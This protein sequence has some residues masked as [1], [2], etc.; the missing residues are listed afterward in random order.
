MNRIISSLGISFWA[1]VSLAQ[2]TPDHLYN[3]VNKPLPVVV[4]AS[5]KLEIHLLEPVTAKDI[6]VAPVKAG[7][8]DLAQTLGLWSRQVKT[9]TY[10]QLY[11]DGRPQGA[12]IVLQPMLSPTVSKLGADGKTVVFE[13][14]EDQAYSGIRAY[15]DSYLQVE[16]S[17]G[18]M[19]FALR[20]DCA[21]NT[22]ANV[23]DYARNELYTDTIFHRVVYKRKDGTRFVIQGG[24]PAGTG[25]GGPG[26]AYALENSPLPHDFGVISIARST[27]PNTNGCQIFVCLSRDGTKHLDG[28]YASFGQL[29]RGAETVVKIALVKVGKDDR[30]EI[31]PVIKRVRLIPAD[32]YP[33]RPLPVSAPKWPDELQ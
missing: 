24:D 8:L 27:D 13:P 16:T 21:P 4:K 19:T 26:W 3:A 14:D 11:A 30:P 7:R 10:A 9:V 20:P 15:A 17:A 22:A 23:L 6:A 5:G 18:N 1:A 12:P 33:L 31:P 29:I 2:L 32:P 25:S 28:K